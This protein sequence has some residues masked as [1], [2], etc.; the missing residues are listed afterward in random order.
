MKF[1][2]LSLVLLLCFVRSSVAVDSWPQ[3]RGPTGQG[4]A[5]TCNVPNEFNH[6]SGLKWRTASRAK[7]G[8]RLW[9]MRG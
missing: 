6:A 3:F 4:Q 8:L 5:K 7:V 9:L 2:K 1:D